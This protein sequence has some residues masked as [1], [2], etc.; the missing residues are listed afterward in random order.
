MQIGPP[1]ERHP[2]LQQAAAS[3]IRSARTTPT[4]PLAAADGYWQRGPR[5]LFMTPTTVKVVA[6]TR[7]RNP[8][9]VNE[10]PTPTRQLAATQAPMC[11]SCGG[12]ARAQLSP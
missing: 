6:V 9:P 5:T 2:P 8:K 10:I 3:D 7:L 11:G 1:R 12:V 4:E